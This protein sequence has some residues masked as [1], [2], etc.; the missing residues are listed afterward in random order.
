MG[1]GQ[2][3]V[4]HF[5]YH[6][7]LHQHTLLESLIGGLQASQFE[8][9]KGKGEGASHLFQTKECL[10]ERGKVERQSVASLDEIIGG[11]YE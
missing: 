1:N 7:L 2:Q 10:K 11:T 8:G 9:L 6:H 5:F 3:D 4:A